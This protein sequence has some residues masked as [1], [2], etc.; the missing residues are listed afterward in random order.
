MYVLLSWQKRRFDSWP[1]LH[2]LLRLHWFLL[3][4]PPTVQTDAHQVIWRCSFA[5][6]CDCGGSCDGLVTFPVCFSSFPPYEHNFCFSEILLFELL[7]YLSCLC[8]LFVLWFIFSPDLCFLVADE[9]KRGVGGVNSLVKLLLS[10]SL[11]W[12]LVLNNECL[13]LFPHLLCVS[14]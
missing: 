4:V 8:L 1:G 13:S 3:W 5:A 10:L 11:A 6:W 12:R 7:G 9:L 14:C 2:V